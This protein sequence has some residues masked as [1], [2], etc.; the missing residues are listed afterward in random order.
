MSVIP[1]KKNNQHL[2]DFILYLL[3]E[4]K[5]I[6]WEKIQRKNEENCLGTHFLDPHEEFY[7]RPITSTTV[8]IGLQL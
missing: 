3:Y 5:V 1:V 2:T 6:L 8:F 7:S 4:D